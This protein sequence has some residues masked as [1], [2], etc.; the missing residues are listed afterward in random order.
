[1]NAWQPR[2][3]AKWM[4]NPFRRLCRRWCSYLN[5][6][7]C[8]EESLQGSGACID[9]R[10]TLGKPSENGGLMGFYGF[11]SLVFPWLAG[12]SPNWME[13]FIGKSLIS[14]L[15]WSIFHC[16]GWFLRETRKHKQLGRWSLHELCHERWWVTGCLV[17]SVL[18]VFGYNDWWPDVDRWITKKQGKIAYW[19]KKWDVPTHQ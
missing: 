6:P 3:R 17:L 19:V 8:S 12:K 1:M 18:R 11:Y 13:M 7:G 15:V 4:S 16:H 2:P 5:R 9:H 10:K 14:I